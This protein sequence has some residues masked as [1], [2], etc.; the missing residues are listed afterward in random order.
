M[1][2][3]GIPNPFGALTP[4]ASGK[5]APSIGGLSVGVFRLPTD[6]LYFMTLTLDNI[7]IGSRYR[8]S[9]HSNNQELATGVAVS[10][11]E[12]ITGIP[13]Y[14]SGMLIDITVRQASASPFYKIFDT[15]VTANPSGVSSYILQQL[16]E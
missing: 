16:D 1:I 8:I 6:P 10:S 7:V 14:S 4:A 11:T 3:V 13:V 12:I 2:L 9:R 15:A 5:A